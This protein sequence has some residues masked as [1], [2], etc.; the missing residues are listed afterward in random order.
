MAQTKFK[1]HVKEEENEITHAHT[2]KTKIKKPIKREQTGGIFSK[3]SS[4]ISSSV[5]LSVHLIKLFEIMTPSQKEQLVDYAKQDGK[6]AACVI[7]DVLI[8]QGIIEED[9]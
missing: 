6:T 9:S 3:F 5:N 7:K 8:E 2:Q 4:P 1:L